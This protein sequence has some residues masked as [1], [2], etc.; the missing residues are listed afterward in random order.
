MTVQELIAEL[1]GFDPNAP[2]HI[3]YPSGDYW[4]TQCAPKITDINELPIK[5]SS[6]HR[7]DIIDEDEDAEIEDNGVVIVIS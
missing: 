2:V 6:Y 4:K 5:Y 1:E 3:R 7:M